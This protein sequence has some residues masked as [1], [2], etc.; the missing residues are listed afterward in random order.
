MLTPGP[1]EMRFE[2]RTLG[3][4]ESH[5]VVIKPGEV[6]TLSLSPAAS[7][8]TVTSTAPAD[9]LID[10][11]IVGQTPLTDHPVALGTH[12]V[13]VRN[14]TEQARRFSTTMTVQPVLIEVDF[15][16]P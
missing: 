5:H 7:L 14:G 1:H 2:N 13:I 11:E 16:K 15:S 12:N 3:Y 6:A 4:R 10:G 8:L 9:V